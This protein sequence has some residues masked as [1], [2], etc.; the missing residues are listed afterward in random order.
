MSLL[1]NL[2][3][4]P[5]MMGG[6]NPSDKWTQESDATVVSDDSTSHS[7]EFSLKVTASAANVG[8]SQEL[9]LESGAEYQVSAHAKVTEGDTARVVIDKGD[10]D[11][12]EIGD[13]TGTSFTEISGKFVATGSSG[14]IYL[15]AE[16]NGDI[17]WFDDVAV[18][19]SGVGHLD[20]VSTDTYQQASRRGDGFWTDGNYAVF[21]AVGNPSQ[22][23]CLWRGKPQFAYD[24]ENDQCLLE[25]YFDSQNYFQVFY[26]SHTNKFT[27]RKRIE[28]TS[29]NATTKK[30]TFAADTEIDIICT[31]DTKN[32][33]KIYYNGSDTGSTANSDTTALQALTATIRGD[34]QSSTN[35]TVVLDSDVSPDDNAYN[36]W[37][38]EIV[39]GTGRGQQRKISDYTGSTQTVSIS[40]SWTTN[41]DNTSSYLLYSSVV[42]IG[43]TNSGVVSA[44][45][46]HNEIAIFSRKLTAHQAQAFHTLNE[47][48]V[49]TN[50]SVMLECTISP[51]DYIEIDCDDLDIIQFDASGN[52]VLSR[53]S[54]GI[55]TKNSRFFMLHPGENLNDG[56]ILWCENNS[57]KIDIWYDLRFM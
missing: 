38:I 2:V 9:F 32:G 18:Y 24:T 29:Y 21:G 27:F 36:D 39:D 23:A 4:N 30:M 10:G 34:V 46:Y 7:G 37:V 8:A 26:N 16:S 50:G 11:V 48:L 12:V 44:N 42:T 33:S 3:E 41:P 49:N 40:N 56:E 25:H 28:G 15:Q 1:D 22:W 35:T 54:N 19:Q 20:L 13:T 6:S 17:V 5:N 55:T 14:M 52:E 57:G 47:P 45:A 51:D 31:F 43:A 53:L